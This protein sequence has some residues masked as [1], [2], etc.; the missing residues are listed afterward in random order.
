M[1][2]VEFVQWA[3]EHMPTSRWRIQ[4][5]LYGDL[6][7]ASTLDPARLAA[8][9]L[10]HQQARDLLSP[11]VDHP[12]LQTSLYVVP[13]AGVKG[14]DEEDVIREIINAM[15]TDEAVIRR[16]RERRRIAQE[17]E[18]L[19]LFRSRDYDSYAILI[20]DRSMSYSRQLAEMLDPE[21]VDSLMRADPGTPWALD[22]LPEGRFYQR[23]FHIEVYN[24]W[25]TRWWSE[26][27]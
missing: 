25:T 18:A 16:I 22:W 14:Q 20:E 13:P 26:E 17:Y 5:S 23:G 3:T 24:Q 6:S 10:L 11:L 15:Y 1:E 4:V 27:M 9:R 19:N 7:L 8:G 21:W 2:S 12:G